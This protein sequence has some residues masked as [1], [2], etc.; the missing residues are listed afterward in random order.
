MWKNNG[1]N[2]AKRSIGRVLEFPLGF[3]FFRFERVRRVMWDVIFH[4]FYILNSVHILIA[5]KHARVI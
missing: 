2:N 3:F 4:S 5:L 1:R